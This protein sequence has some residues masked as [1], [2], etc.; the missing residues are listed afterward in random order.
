MS[1]LFLFYFHQ[2]FFQVLIIFTGNYN[3]FNLLA[4]ALLLPILDDEHLV[5]ILPSWLG[6][7]SV[8]YRYFIMPCKHS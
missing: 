1:Y 3:F 4:I 2:L 8:I 5:T 7:E 6:E